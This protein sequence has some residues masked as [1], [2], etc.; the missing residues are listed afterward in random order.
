MKNIALA[1]SLILLLVVLIGVFRTVFER[2]RP[3]IR[4]FNEESRHA[5]I[6]LLVA[7]AALFTWSRLNHIQIDSLEIAGV[8]ASVGTLQE[9]VASLSDQMEVFFKS[10]RIEMFDSKNWDGVKKNS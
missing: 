6:A 8:R 9:K 7:A 1:V 5:Y 10:K 4:K 3:Y 2:S